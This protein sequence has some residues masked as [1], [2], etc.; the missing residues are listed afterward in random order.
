MS[1]SRQFLVPIN[2]DITKDVYPVDENVRKRQYPMNDVMSPK[3]YRQIY[4]DPYI[5]GSYISS[6][7][8][9]DKLR[10]RAKFR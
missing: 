10:L 5:A 8:Y 2:Y 7:C 3:E 9:A 1:N 4:I 6:A